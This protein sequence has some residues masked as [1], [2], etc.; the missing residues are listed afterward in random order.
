MVARSIVVTPPGVEPVSL[1]EA[2]LDRG[3][4]HTDDDS[5]LEFLIAN[6]RQYAETYMRRSLITQQRQLVLDAFPGCIRVPYG[7]VISVTSISYVDSDGTTQTLSPSLYQVDAVSDL[8]RIIPE[9]GESWPDTKPG[10]NRVT[11]IYE[12]GYGNAADDVPADI[13]HAIRL[14]V[15]TGYEMR[16]ESDIPDSA[17][18]ML[19]PYV[20]YAGDD[21]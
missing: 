16:E 11:V 7:R 3:L 6:A 2:R 19:R 15:G 18:A 12:A 14:M 1:A 13:R 9:Y 20:V 21:A 17:R 5:M 10:L 8:A 4:V